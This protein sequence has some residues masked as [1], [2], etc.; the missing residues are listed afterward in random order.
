MTVYK[1]HVDRNEQI[2]EY[3]MRRRNARKLN[4]PSLDNLLDTPIT[5]E[6]Y[7]AGIASYKTIEN[8]KGEFFDIQIG[9]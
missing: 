3:W 7:F 4:F 1:F 8:R 2:L 6:K 9:V 5:F